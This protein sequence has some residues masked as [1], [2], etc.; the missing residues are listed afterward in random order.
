MPS[1]VWLYAANLVLLA[2]HQVDA[3][4]WHEWDVFGVPG[5]LEFFLVFNVFAMNVLSVGLV[6][7]AQE[8][9]SARAFVGPCAGP[10]PKSAFREMKIWSTSSW[11]VAEKVEPKF[12]CAMRPAQRMAP[13]TW[14]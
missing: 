5:G 12:V 10:R 1:R 8:R 7:V 11:L 13:S 6:H 2:T 3:A 9:G 4:F 14:P